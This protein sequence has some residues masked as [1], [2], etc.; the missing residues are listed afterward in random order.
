MNG[1]SFASLFAVCCL[2]FAASSLPAAEIKAPMLAVPESIAAE[3]VPP[4][5]RTHD[6]DLLPYENIRGAILADWH[7]KE[8]RMLIGTRF[9]ESVQ[10]HEVAMPMG[11]RTQ[12]TFYRD[13]IN[14]SLYRPSDPDQVVYSLNEGGAENYQLFLLDRRTGRSRRFTDGTHR[15]VAPRWSRNGKW[16]AYS[17]NARNGRDMDV[18]V[19]DPSTPGSERRLVE[20][21]GDWH[22][23]EWSADDRRLLLMEEISANETYL[24]WVDVA[25]GELHTITPRNPRKEEPTVAYASGRWSAD[26]QSIFTTNDQGSEFQRLARIDL[27]TGRQTVLSGDIPWDVESFDLSD[28]GGL[29]A[30]LT[31]EDGIS[32]LHFLDAA[33]GN[34]LPAPQ[35]PAGIARDLGFRPGSHEVGFSLD[36]ARSPRDI[37]SYDVDS[38]RLERW[39][40]SEAG[41]LNAETFAVP[42]L[43]HFPT[44]DT[45]QDGARRTIPAFVYRPAADRFK[46]R[47]PVYIDIHGGPEGQSRPGFRGSNNYLLDEMG[48]ALIYPNVRG[49][50]GYG[51]SYLKLDNGRLREDSVK[52][53]GA[54]LDWIAAQPDLDSSRIMVA[55]GSYGGY[56]SLAVMT[57]YSDRLCCGWDS[58]GISNF[59]TF[60]E[61]TQEYRRDLRRVEYGDERDPQ[62]RAFLEQIA[63]VKRAGRITK[64]L[65]VSAGANDPRVPV[66]ESAQIA[67]AVKGNGVPVWYLVGKDEGHG[68]AKKSNSDYQRAVLF[69][70][71]R[72]YLLGE[73]EQAAG[74]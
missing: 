10:L 74:K 43:I 26:G 51:K 28:D 62:M 20:V 39:T 38:R 4:I 25:S 40:A 56:M 19:A 27:A 21:Q 59:V 49:S 5:A 57:F 46:G 55:G 11:A 6:Q 41:G 66:T 32:K 34:S 23:V 53:I 72:R 61:H 65:L 13:A 12:L 1:K 63:P 42:E 22:A 47:R 30:F 36:W 64:P 18:Y 68:F 16:L 54:L 60:L 31:N 45:S 8:R 24:H 58:V 67:A 14:D 2:V 17:S 35:L 48:V 7:P 69:E 52:D 73:G 9:A 3:G 29:L 33:T 15:Y 70:F 71:M 44:F 37:Y 50:A